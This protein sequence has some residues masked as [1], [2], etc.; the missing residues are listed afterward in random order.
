[1]LCLGVLQA[2]QRCF[3]GTF[4]LSLPTKTGIPLIKF[5]YQCC[6]GIK[7]SQLLLFPS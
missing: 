5:S 7:P 6:R 1:M 4:Q 2:D 3:L